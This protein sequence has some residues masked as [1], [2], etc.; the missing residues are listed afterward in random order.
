MYVTKMGDGGWLVVVREH[1]RNSLGF[2]GGWWGMFFFVS[3]AAFILVFDSVI[4]FSCHAKLRIS[5]KAG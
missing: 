2:C 1:W 3:T 4:L 5:A